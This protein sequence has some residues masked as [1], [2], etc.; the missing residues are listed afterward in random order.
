MVPVRVSSFR[1]AG[2]STSGVWRGRQPDMGL[3]NISLTF[4][5][6]LPK[7]SEIRN[8]SSA[9]NGYKTQLTSLCPGFLTCELGP[10]LCVGELH[11]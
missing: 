9:G 6:I 11:F 4:K 10:V 8:E 1:Q 2:G 5:A 3:L 7:S